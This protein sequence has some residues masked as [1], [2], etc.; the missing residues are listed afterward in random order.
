MDYKGKLKEFIVKLLDNIHEQRKLILALS[1]IVVFVTTYVL[2][3]PAFTLE[4]DEAA[5]QGGITLATEDM[6]ASHEDEGNEVNKIESTSDRADNELDSDTSGELKFKGKDY[7]ITVSYGLEARI[8]SG[9]ILTAEELKP[10][11]EEYKKHYTKLLQTLKD[12]TEKT[13]APDED[14]MPDDPGDNEVKEDLAKMGL[15]IVS[16]DSDIQIPFVRFFDITILS[17]GEEIEPSAA[18]DVSIVY[19]EPIEVTDNV[20]AQVVHFAEDGTELIEAETDQADGNK[21]E[22]STFDYQQSSFSI[23][24]TLLKYTEGITEGHY[25][26]IKGTRDNNGVEHYYAMTSNGSA[27]EVRKNGDTFSNIPDDSSWNF[28]RAV[29]GNFYIENDMYYSWLTLYN[30]VTGS[31]QQDIVVGPS[32]AGKTAVYFKNPNGAPL[33]WNGSSNSFVVMNPGSNTESFYIA[34]ANS[35][36]EH[37]TGDD[38]KPA[39]ETDLGDLYAIRDKINNSKIIADKTASVFDYDNRIYQIDLKALS[40]VTIFNNKVDLELIVDT[41]RSMYFPA[42]LNPV[43]NTTFNKIAGTDR[44][45]LT[46]VVNGLDKNQVYYFVGEGEKA[47][48]FALYYAASGTNQNDHSGEEHWRFVDASYMNPPDAAAMNQSDT[49]NRLSGKNIEDFNFA[50]NLDDNNLCRLYTSPDGITRLAYLKEAVRIAS[51]IVYALDRNNQIGLVTFNSTA[52]NPRFY[53]YNQRNNLYTAIT[54]ISLAGGTRQDLGLE[55]GIGLFNSSGRPDAQKIAILITDGAP[56]MRDN[57]NQQIPSD[58][59]WQMIGEKADQ[60]K[61]N[62]STNAKLYT[63]GLSLDMVGGN[64]QSHLDG[65]ASEEDNVTR[66]FNAQNG[67]QIASA[68]KSLIETLV[69]DATLEAEVTDVLD[70]AFYPV[71]ENGEPI[72]P[73]DYYDQDGKKYTWSIENVNGA[74]CWKVT[75]YDQVVGRG[76]KN[77]DDTIKTPGWQKSIYVKA[78]EDFLGGNNIETNRYYRSNNVVKPIK[79]VYTE[80]GT[81]EI[82]KINAPSNAQWGRFDKTPHVN[83]DEL[84][85][86]EH[87]TEWTVYL[88]TEVTPR[89]QLYELWDN[90]KFKQVVKDGG[91]EQNG[92]IMTG[93]DQMW[94]PHGTTVNENDDNPPADNAQNAKLELSHYPELDE[95]YDALLTA[96]TDGTDYDSGNIP[97]A[98]YGHGTVGNLRVTAVKTIASGASDALDKAP[99]QHITDKVASPAEKYVITVTYTPLTDGAAA[100][101]PQCERPGKITS[102][103]GEDEVKSENIHKINVYA[104]KLTI[105][106]VDQSDVTITTDQA[107]FKLFRK[108]TADDEPGSYVSDAPDSLPGGNNYVLVETLNTSNGTVTTGDLNDSYEYYLV[109]TKAPSGFSTLPGYMN[110]SIDLQ[111]T[112]TSTLDPSQTSAEKWSPWILSDWLQKS[113]V[114]VSAG[115]SSMEGYVKYGESGDGAGYDYDSNTS[116][117]VYRIRNDAGVVLPHTGGIGTTIFYILGSI[118]VIGGGIYF[119]S[120]RRI[121]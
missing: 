11:T 100:S 94:Y 19:D 1:C 85:L 70:P 115:D 108:A 105:K 62:N 90:I 3:L 73:G 14:S 2:I 8:P 74:D 119:V 89:E 7:L 47:T 101:Y 65:L 63:L 110:V 113:K 40:D 56:N 33:R 51:E 50:I 61:G 54:N 117:V 93:A 53:T 13:K 46:Q 81:G 43:P 32:N 15:E 39:G 76:E 95:Q 121:K 38:F 58:R 31:W 27:V 111:D 71:N 24:A 75:Y 118:L 52:N 91:T 116:S 10:G 30:G 42:T 5:K 97:Y 87:S 26:I 12:D 48:V 109:E 20:E 23:T 69:Y 25:V 64:N 60:L 49:I 96:I 77:S 106:K 29:N 83:V 79:Y 104:K 55:K 44:Y 66:H 103:A 88:G 78:K 22:I 17:N 112:Y 102:G 41:S 82:K 6:S 35:D 18:V 107:T 84:H 72:A 34:R 114:I 45:S 99:D 92:S 68:V 59:A 9:A 4:K 37:G 36:I 120:R 28:T 16:A 67:P 57:N 86:T 80:K 21:D 98:P